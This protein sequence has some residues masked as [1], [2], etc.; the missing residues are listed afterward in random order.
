MKDIIKK[1]NDINLLTDIYVLSNPYN[2]TIN[3][4]ALIDIVN[5][6]NHPKDKIHILTYD[7]VTID[8]T[9]SKIYKLFD[10][11]VGKSNPMSSFCIITPEDLYYNIEKVFK[12]VSYGKGI[13]EDDILVEL[14]YPARINTLSIYRPFISKTREDIESYL[15]SVNIEYSDF[16]HKLDGDVFLRGIIN[17]IKTENPDFYKD[18][19][20]SMSSIKSDYID[21]E[22]SSDMIP[23]SFS[24]YRHT[25][26]EPIICKMYLDYSDYGG[27]FQP[28]LDLSRKTH[29]LAVI[30]LLRSVYNFEVSE[31]TL[32]EA[33]D[34]FSTG[35]SGVDDNCVVFG[36]DL[37]FCLTM[38]ND[39]Y[40]VV[41]EKFYNS[42]DYASEPFK[43][44]DYILNDNDIII[45]NNR[46]LRFGELCNEYKIPF[47]IR[48]KVRGFRLID[49][50]AYFMDSVVFSKY[51]NN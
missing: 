12:N 23:L 31:S 30:N 48:N 37:K 34:I 43:N 49:S 42:T 24:E 1:I 27:I 15:E 41:D 50:D 38:I 10:L 22:K 7:G 2:E 44:C 47:F 18:F 29:R 5:K 6:S 8:Y 11:I 20:N 39:N 40:Y 9:G 13:I 14:E 28:E 21:L 25:L 17:F 32:I 35:L 51:I 26:K 3:N 19:N 4:K 36:D 46:E 16:S 33:Y 45:F